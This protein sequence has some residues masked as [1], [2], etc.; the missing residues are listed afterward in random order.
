MVIKTTLLDGVH[1]CQPHKKNKYN[2]FRR[3]NKVYKK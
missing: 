1:L 2:I 3:E